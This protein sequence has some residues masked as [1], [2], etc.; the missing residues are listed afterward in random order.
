RAQQLEEKGD[1]VIVYTDESY[2]NVY[3]KQEKTWFK[4]GEKSEHSTGKGKRL[5]IVHAITKDGPLVTWEGQEWGKHPI[6]EGWFKASGSNS[7]SQSKGAEAAAAGA[8]VAAQAW[9]DAGCKGQPS[10]RARSVAV[11][12]AVFEAA[13]E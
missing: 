9:E 6:K 2:I 11:R 13:R 12:K 10:S 4:S 3:H 8:E 1:H 5:I 7:I